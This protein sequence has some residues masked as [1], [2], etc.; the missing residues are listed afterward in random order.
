MT[1]TRRT[2]LAYAVAVALAAGLPFVSAALAPRGAALCARDGIEIGTLLRIRIET[3]DGTSLA[4]CSVRCAEDWIAH[5]AP[6]RDPGRLRVFVTDETTG[7]EIDVHDAVFVR[8]RI[9]TLRTTE[10]RIHA[11]GRRAD[12]ASHAAAFGGLLLEG[13]DRPFRNLPQEPPR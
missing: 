1:P 2:L 7:S 10:E 6:G 12:A 4:F 11:F 9:L 3:A 13:D 5:A 8:S